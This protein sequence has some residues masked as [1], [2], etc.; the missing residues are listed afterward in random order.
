M[1]TRDGGTLLASLSQAVRSSAFFVAKS[2][3]SDYVTACFILNGL[4]GT[5]TVPHTSQQIG[6][7]HSWV[8]ICLLMHTLMAWVM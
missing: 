3:M 4:T 7:S 6:S 2:C 5:L 1:W 8:R